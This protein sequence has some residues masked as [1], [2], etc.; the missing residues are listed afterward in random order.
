MCKDDPSAAILSDIKIINF[1]GKTSGMYDPDVANIDCPPRG[2][3]DL[4]FVGWDVIAPSK[5][6]TVLCDYY[7]HPRGVKCTHGAFG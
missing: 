5:N 6:S 4:T 3:C 7:D 2:T 1:T